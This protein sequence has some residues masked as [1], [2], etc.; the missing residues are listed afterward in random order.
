MHSELIVDLVRRLD[1]QDYSGDHSF[2]VFKDYQQMLPQTVAARA[3][4]SAR[5]LAEQLLPRAMPIP[6]EMHLR[7]AETSF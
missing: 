5:W 3:Q 2:K 6:G 4:R 1:E 7:A